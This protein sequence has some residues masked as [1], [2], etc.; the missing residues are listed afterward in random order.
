MSVTKESWS[1]FEPDVAKVYLNGYGHPSDRSKHLVASVL[2]E[3]FGKREFRIADFGCGNGHL[4]GF[5]RDCGLNLH[6]T[7]FDFSTSLLQAARELFPDDERAIF[8]DRDIQDPEADLGQAD[9]VLYSHVLETLESPGASLAAAR[10]MAPRI[11]VRFFDP[12]TERLDSSEI[13]RLSTGNNN[14]NVPYL[15]RS[16]STGYYLLLLDGVRCKSVDVHQVEGD[17]DQVHLLNF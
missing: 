5:F 17:R 1:S 2:K 9:I 12:P 10:R 13:R 14:T 11:M 6:Y 8:L 3:L 4:Y 15:R 7:G 16:F